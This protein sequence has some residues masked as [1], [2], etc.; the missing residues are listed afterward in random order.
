[1][2]EE[3]IRRPPGRP[4]SEDHDEAILAATIAL[5][6]EKGYAA[7]TVEGVAARAGVAK[8]TIYRRWPGKAALAMDAFLA[9]VSAEAPCPDTGSAQVDFRLQLRALV[10]LF[11]KPHVRQLLAGV[12]YEAQADPT[13]AEAFRDRY[14]AARRGEGS[15]VLRRGIERGELDPALDH[16]TFFDQLYGALYF[17]LLFGTGSLPPRFADRLVDAM[18]RDPFPRE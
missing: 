5:F 16:E 15:E 3:A 6:A 18:F 4:R 13:V 7:L 14:L 11:S 17:R 2:S 10:A 1:M 9:E 8:T 12:A